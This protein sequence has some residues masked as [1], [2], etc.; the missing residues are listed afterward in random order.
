MTAHSSLYFSFK[1]VRGDPQRG[2]TWEQWPF[3]E[4]HPW[5]SWAS[6]PAPH[7]TGKTWVTK[8]YLLIINAEPLTTVLY[9]H[10]I[11]FSASQ[12]SCSLHSLVR[13]ALNI[14]LDLEVPG[15]PRMCFLVIFHELCRLSNCASS[16]FWRSS[17][18]V[19]HLN[20]QNS[21]EDQEREEQGS[22][23]ALL[24]LRWTG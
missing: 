16:S 13:T 21:P 10:I 23:F 4:G 11:M 24:F 14:S 2:N 3:S 9:L 6:R 1:E 20:R 8:K 5:P 15:Y 18:N 12:I 7:Q 22:P 19:L 17:C